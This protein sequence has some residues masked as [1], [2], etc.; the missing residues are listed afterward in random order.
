MKDLRDLFISNVLGF[1]WSST[2]KSG[3]VT[4]K[5]R[6]KQS[7]GVLIDASKLFL[8]KSSPPTSSDVASAD[9]EGIALPDEERISSPALRGSAN[10]RPLI[11]TIELHPTVVF[12][13][14]RPRD[15]A[16]PASWHDFRAWAH[17]ILAFIL[18]IILRRPEM[19]LDRE[20]FAIIPAPFYKHDDEAYLR[21]YS[22]RGWIPLFKRTDGS[23]FP[24]G[25]SRCACTE[26]TMRKAHAT[27]DDKWI[28]I[29][30]LL[31]FVEASDPLQY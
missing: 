8:R 12:I 15:I 24:A 6:A 16:L 28:T 20:I 17:F 13:L 3:N 4:Q 30:K 27:C 21:P 2:M 31:R 14:Y 1:V 5:S 19:R 9:E 22:V 29:D 18:S 26:D 10:L 11:R 7:D 23:G 25:F